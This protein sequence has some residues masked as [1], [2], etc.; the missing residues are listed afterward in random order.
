MTKRQIDHTPAEPSW[1]SIIGWALLA[2]IGI[3]IAT[4]FWWGR[5]TAGGTA[6]LLISGG[7]LGRA[8][9]GVVDRGTV[10]MNRAVLGAQRYRALQGAAERVVDGYVKR[11]GDDE[12][13]TWAQLPNQPGAVLTVRWAAAEEVYYVS[14]WIS[15]NWQITGERRWPD[16]ATLR[17]VVREAEID[18]LQPADDAGTRAIRARMNLRDREVWV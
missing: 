17:N 18:G 6:L 15:D 13:G 9:A 10:Q 1:L 12:T 7:A 11:H 2:S 4:Y 3:A 5:D 8:V 16:Q 14:G